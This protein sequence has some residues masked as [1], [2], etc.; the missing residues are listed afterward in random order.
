MQL[1]ETIELS[2]K[3]FPKPLP[4]QADIMVQ[5]FAKTG[6]IFKHLDRT[7]LLNEIYSPDRL[8]QLKKLLEAKGLYLEIDHS[9]WTEYEDEDFEQHPLWILLFPDIFIDEIDFEKTCKTCNKKNVCIDTNKKVPFVNSKKPIVSVNGDFTIVRK[10][11]KKK[12][13]IELKGANFEPFDEKGEYFYLL[14]KGNLGELVNSSDDFIGYNG[15]C[16]E[17]NQPIFKMFFGAFKYSKS[18]WNGDDIVSGSFHSVRFY[19]KKAYQL[20][21]SVEKELSRYGVVILK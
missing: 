15:I 12:M 5:F 8:S 2:G 1:R 9:I 16:P 3:P 13:E 18:N 7:L 21:K 14:S 6:F 11:L 19:T 17:C 20:L 10:D 4:I